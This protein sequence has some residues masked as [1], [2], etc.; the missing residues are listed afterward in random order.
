MELVDGVTLR[1]AI[2][3]RTLD[4][5]TVVPIAIQIA[6]ALEA[7]HARNI[8]HRDVK[9]GNVIITGRGHVKVLDFG[10]AKLAPGAATDT[11]RRSNR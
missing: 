4:P 7:A 11:R 10:L 9:P 5:S 3:K 8:V 2:E 1:Q 6:D